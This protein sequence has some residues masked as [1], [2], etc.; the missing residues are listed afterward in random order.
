VLAWVRALEAGGLAVLAPLVLLAL[1]LDGDGVAA[2]VAREPLLYVQVALAAWA[3]LVLAGAWCGHRELRLV[4]A[5]AEAESL[6]VTDALTGLKNLRYFRAR[7]A[8]ACARTRRD[9]RPVALVVIDL[10]HFKA[11]NDQ[12]GHAAGDRVLAR[13]ACAVTSVC[14][15]S[16]T[17]ARI[18]GEE[19][20]VILP[21]ADREAARVAA[22]RIRRAIS[23]QVVHL[24]GV[25]GRP[26][27]SRALS[28]T[29]SLGVASSQELALRTPEALFEAA[30]RAL[31]VA[32]ASGRNCTRLAPRLRAGSRQT[33]AEP[34]ASDTYS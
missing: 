6:A 8:E 1:R 3:P 5:R 20:A 11:I 30:D 34:A 31:F 13:V 7:L 22:E 26:G 33:T 28:V 15:A 4:T 10:D 18:G 24:E 17:A 19:L 16:E 9:G 29:A 27:G 32:K 2:A 12:H 25:G 23:A 21:G 14:R